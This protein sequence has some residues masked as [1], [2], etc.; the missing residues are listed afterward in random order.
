MSPGGSQQEPSMEEIL[1]SIR[2]I[3]S[4]EDD[5]GKDKVQKPTEPEAA[6]V[7]E[8]TEVVEDDSTTVDRMPESVSSEFEA[9]AAEGELPA[10]T[11]AA[12]AGGES[13]AAMEEAGGEPE[14]ERSLEPAGEA[15]SGGSE[16]E[17]GGTALPQGQPAAGGDERLVS[18]EAAGTATA[19]LAELARAVERSPTA[20]AESSGEGQRSV[21]ALV[22]EI[23]RPML[24]EWLDKNLPP[25]IERL[26]QK[27]IRHLARRA[28][29][30]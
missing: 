22:A 19:T 5:G 15:E 9:E 2:Q 25:I 18:A 20:P 26:V 1:A 28:E 16:V 30:D 11:E 7:L 17:Q 4:K 29:P 14:S 27:E 24:G 12:A 8:L 13:A 10:A 3:I 21:E 6:D 23:L